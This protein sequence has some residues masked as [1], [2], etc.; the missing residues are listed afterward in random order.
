MPGEVLFY[1]KHE[2]L[3][4]INVP[5]SIAI[6]LLY[7]SLFLE[8]T[9]SISVVLQSTAEAVGPPFRGPH[10][11]VVAQYPTSLHSACIHS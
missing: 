10:S 4:I 9:M 5:I 8:K 1:I 6:V 2:G 3:G 11:S 7:V